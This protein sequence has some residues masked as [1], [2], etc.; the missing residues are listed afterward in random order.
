MHLQLSATLFALL[1]TLFAKTNAQS[2]TEPFEIKM[3]E[4]KISGSRYSN[5]RLLDARRDTS[6][7]GIVQVGMFNAKARVVA[8]TRFDDQLKNLL[9][10]LNDSTAAEG[11]LLL[12]L[13]QF[14]F[15]EVIGAM[16]EKGYCFV[17]AN[18]FAVNDSSYSLVNSIDT[19]IIFNAMDATKKLLRKGSETITDFIAANLTISGADSIQ[20]N[21]AAVLGIDSIEKRRI[22]LYNVNHYEEGVYKTYAAF[23]TQVPD[24]KNIIVKMEDSSVKN[25]KVRY[26][27]ETTEKLRSKDIYA[28][29]YKGL[30]YIAT[31]FGYYPLSKNGDDLFFTGQAKVNAN[32]ADVAA[33]SFFFG[34]IGGLLASND[35]AVFEMKIDHLN[36]GFIHLREI[37]SVVPVSN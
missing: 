24:Y 1:L 26:E 18:L 9:S 11:K 6:N 8:K 25:V 15:A 2:K 28:V 34:I 16:S 4:Q 14:S 19:V 13:R 36:G 27:D 32:G 17:R 35:S 33:A 7:F 5:I 21:Y 30:P 23:K 10:A 3:P 12:Q 37:P 22:P 31:S 20:Y 29:V